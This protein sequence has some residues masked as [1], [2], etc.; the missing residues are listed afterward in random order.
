MPVY[1]QD[2]EIKA[3]TFDFWW[4]LFVDAN[5][6][7]DDSVLN[8]RLEYITEMASLFNLKVRLEDAEKAFDAGRKYFEMRHKN[9]IFVSPEELTSKIFFELGISLKPHEA[10]LIAEKLSH[11][12]IYSKLKALD[13]AEDLLAFLKSKD[14]KT[15]VISDTVMTKG[16][17]LT[18]HLRRH[19]LL[20]YF[21]HLV[22]S[23]EVA[24]VKPNRVPFETAAKK[25]DVKPMQCLHIGDFPWSDIEGALNCGF[26]AVQF[27]GGGSPEARNI[28]PEADFVAKNFKEILLTLKVE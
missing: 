13:G 9:G 21:D 2:R 16:R 11:M 1:F 4:T 17:H 28:H 23:D 14:I 7:A 8:L 5:G 24:S 26:C 25:L 18:W 12:G 22:Y 15:A 20:R 19:R 3:V 6:R 27:V 10:R